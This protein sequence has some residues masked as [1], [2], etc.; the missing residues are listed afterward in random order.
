MRHLIAV[1]DARTLSPKNICYYCAE[2]KEL[3][4]S[5]IS[6]AKKFLEEGKVKDRDFGKYH[7]EPIEG[8]NST[9]YMVDLNE[10]SCN[11]QY[12]V[13]SGRICSHIL[14]AIFYRR[15]KQHEDVKSICNLDG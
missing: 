10:K 11:C 9:T 3:S 5:V 4:G 7:V 1:E 13:M 15:I 12:N 6:K 14:A 2:T 8:Y